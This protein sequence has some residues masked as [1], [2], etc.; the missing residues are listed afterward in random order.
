MKKYICILS[1]LVAASHLLAQ[2]VTP[3]YTES[4][5]SAAGNPSNIRLITKEEFEGQGPIT[6]K[7]DQVLVIPMQYPVHYGPNSKKLIMTSTG[8][9]V[10]VPL[11]YQTKWFNNEEGLNFKTNVACIPKKVGMAAIQF[12]DDEITVKEFNIQV[13]D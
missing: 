9:E 2:E 12:L 6:L 3:D 1:V 13:V 4:F 7:I 10:M 5:P 8:E 11:L